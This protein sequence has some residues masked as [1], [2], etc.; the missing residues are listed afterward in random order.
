M[1]FNANDYVWSGDPSVISG[2]CY[3]GDNS[4]NAKDGKFILTNSQIIVSSAESLTIIPLKF[5]AHL[6]SEKSGYG[7]GRYLRIYTCSH[8]ALTLYFPDAPAWLEWME[9]IV[10]EI[11][12]RIG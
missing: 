9:K 2:N 7:S 8:T 12:K 6:S 3:V 4:Q 5:I 10:K 1:K 11:S